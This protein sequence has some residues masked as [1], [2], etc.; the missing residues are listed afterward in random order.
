LSNLSSS[1]LDNS[2]IHTL[3]LFYRSLTLAERLEFK[4]ICRA[5]ERKAQTVWGAD[6]KI[7]KEEEGERMDLLLLFVILQLVYV[8]VYSLY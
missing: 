8:Y 2:Y 7:K 6:I 5:F 3:N 4:T 1:I